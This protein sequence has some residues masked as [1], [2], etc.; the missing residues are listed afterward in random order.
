M[1][2]PIETNGPY[3]PTWTSI[4]Q[5][6]PPSPPA[7]L[8]QAKFG[9]WVHYG[10]EAN[11]QAGDWSAQH[12]Y[13]QG[14]SA[15]NNHTNLFGYPTTNG[16]KD[17]V[18]S[19]NPSNLNIP[20][21]TQLYYNIGARFLIIQGVHHDQFDEWNSQ[22][23]AWNAMNF[24]PHLDAVGAWM[25]NGHALGMRVGVAFHHEYGWFFYAPGYSWDSTGPFAGIPYDTITATNGTG[26]WWQN[27]DP[28]RLYTINLRE[29]QGWNNT[30]TGY[31]N[32][33]QGILVN[34]LAY[35]NWYATQWALR[36]MD[37]IENYNPDFIYTD[38]NSTQPF[39][40]YA[41][42]S[43]YKCDAMQRVIAHFYNRGLERRT[44]MDLYSFI[45]FHPPSTGVATTS[46][47]SFPAGIVTDQPWIGEQTIGDWYWYPTIGYDT[48]NLIVTRMLECVCRDGA[49]AV[50][51]P[52]R[53][54]GALDPGGSNMLASV[55]QWMGTNGEGIYG[56]HAWTE[57]SDG[58]FRFTVGA[59]GY[60]YAYYEGVPAAG[61]K[62]TLPTLK[63]GN[64]LLT[65]PVSS[66]N[67]TMLGSTAT[68][69]VSQSTTNLSITCPTPMPPT[70]IGTAVCF[71]IG[72][73]SLIGTPAPYGVQA[74]PGTN[75][76]NLSWVDPSLTATYIV[77]RSNTQGGPYG[78]IVAGLTNL[79]Y[80]DTN[81]VANALYYYVVTAV[82]TGGASGMSA[83]AGACLA[84]PVSTNWLSE[85][86][87]AVG[88]AGSYN[89]SGSTFTLNGS[90]SDIWNAADAF[91]YVF[92]AVTGDFTITARVISG[93]DTGSSAKVGVMLR[94]TLNPDAAYAMTFM[95][96]VTAN[97]VEFQDR[98]STDNSAAGVANVA[99]TAPYW[100]RAAR[101]ANIFT[102]YY[103][104]D[105][106]N[107]TSLGSLEVVMHTNMYAGL[108]VCSTANGTLDQGQFDNVSITVSP[109]P[110]AP[111]AP[112]SLSAF[113]GN[114]QVNL[115][116]PA[117]AGAT[118]FNLLRS[119][120]NHD[121]YPVLVTNLLTAAY[122]DASVT[123]AIT[124][125]YEVNAFNSVGISG[126]SPKISVTP[127]PLTLPSP[128]VQMDIGGPAAAGSGGYNSGTF[129]F[130]GSGVDIW[131][132][133]DSFHY[134]YFPV[135]GNG[136]LTARVVNMQNTA[137]YA[138]ASVMFRAS[139]NAN[140]T[141]AAVHMGPTVGTSFQDR[142]TIGGSAAQ[143]SATSG[144]L[145]PYWLQISRTGNIFTGYNS[146]D[147]SNWTSMGTTTITMATNVLAGLAVCSVNN[148]VLCQATFDNVSWSPAT[149][150]PPAPGGLLTAAG[151]SQVV[152]SWLA[153]ANAS[154]YS[155]WNSTTNGGSYAVV[156]SNLTS[157]AYTNTGLSD[158]TVYYYVV[159]AANTAGS[160]GNSVQVSARPVS[161]VPPQAACVLT[162]NQIQLSWPADHTG[163]ELQAQTNPAGSGIT[164][165]W[166]ILPNTY[167]D[168]QFSTSPSTG[169]GN[170]FYRLVYP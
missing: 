7:W 97:G 80:V 123:N 2:F 56:S 92:Q 50:N 74:V 63:S 53:P 159:T 169:G 70:P 11:L 165:N 35:A 1:T 45:K 138:K 90:G 78:I 39:S 52:I 104:A 147:G 13:Q 6:Y 164:T 36:I 72:P 4:A 134:A 85:D 10:P 106:T 124:Y 58:N 121:P 71:K 136:T 130:S 28:R 3:Q 32:P 109:V 140:S 170:V 49:Y 155:L 95:A 68:L 15:Y 166:V 77:R 42:G 148:G 102:G 8:R 167:L 111:A 133:A 161:L 149:T 48:G 18:H 127:N 91:R 162:N 143:V 116:W 81:V 153:S 128:W 135:N 101:N 141:F 79:T 160:S 89:I 163:W 61:T 12:M 9:I 65:G 115:S 87:G 16:Y 88:V 46:E 126:N 84:G 131:N 120:I 150:A 113:G 24:G 30:G 14:T 154:T 100:V 112:G 151:D 93:Q 22:Y 144:Q 105:G 27:Y 62:L 107:W 114:G 44:N 66:G 29:Y 146:P 73:P 96:P 129:A 157:L 51:V 43:G 23:Q 54:D 38:G 168:N 60:L 19:W 117:P 142:T 108:E 82:D 31:Y 69:V 118:G 67:V 41:T 86:V 33:S 25:T 94:D 152:V 47:S 37:V 21:L 156:V 59:N 122:T 5:N 119:T 76:I 99:A 139:T 145:P 20:N 40:G 17:V 75:Q 110:Q 64:S 83:E 137:T 26:T 57:F 98:S 125:Y 103:S 132:T 34:H 55:G 158:G